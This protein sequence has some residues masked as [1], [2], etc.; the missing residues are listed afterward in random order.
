[1]NRRSIT[2]GLVIVA[3]TAA[4]TVV[5]V[6]SSVEA[7]SSQL[8]AKLRD[9]SGRVVGVVT[10]RVHPH[11]TE[12]RAVLRPN[13]SV[14]PGAFHGFHV[15]ANSDPANGS[16]CIADAAQAPATWFVSADGHLSEPGQTHGQHDGDMPSPRVEADGTARLEFTT[17]TLR[18][19]DLRG[20]AVILHANPDNF[21]NV[22]TGPDG[23][24][25]TPNSAAATDLTQ[26][27]GNAGTR[28]ACGVV[29]RHR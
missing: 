22:P 29:H 27:T 15:H 8:T 2:A 11:D 9:P 1:M 13:P 14:T 12:V 24:Q 28:V 20:R 7:H 26:R 16:G 23:T 19:G 6:N 17:D 3:A 10:F 25:Y 21:G 18:L 4:T 5:A